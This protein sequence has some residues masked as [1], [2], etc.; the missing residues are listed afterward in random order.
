M[1]THKH[2]GSVRS[3]CRRLGV[4]FFVAAGLATVIAPVSAR[5]VPRNLGG[6]LGR[7]ATSPGA[8]SASATR[9][10]APG[11]LATVGDTGAV[12]TVSPVTV[13][14]AAG[15]VL[16]LVTLNGKEPVD[17]VAQRLRALPGVDVR[18]TDAHY[19]AGVV[20][21]LVP[22]AQLAGIATM[23]S[24]LAVVPSSPVVHDVGAATSQGV[25]QHRV[26]K[27]SAGVD[28]SGITVGVLSDSYDTS[29]SPIKAADDIA[30]GDLP[31]PGNPLGNTQPVVVLQ[32]FPDGTD[33]GRAML[34]IVHDLAPKARLGFATA[35]TGEV[36]F[37]NNIR[38]LAGLPGAPGAIPGFKADVIADDVVYLAEPFFQDGIIAQAVD[39]VADAGV[40]YFSSA[41]NRPASQA[42]DSKL[43][44]VPADPSSW[45]GTNLDFSD[46][47][48]AL[49]AGGFHNFAEDGSLDIA[50]TIAIGSS[51]TIVFQWNEPF[52]PVPPIPVQTLASGASTVPAD[53]GYDV[54][55]FTGT[56]G[57]I[58]AITVDGDPSHGNAN[59]D[60]TITLYGPDFGFLGFQ[61]STTNPETLILQLPSDGTYYV[62]VSGYNGALGDYVYTVQEVQI[63]ERVLS[64]FNLLF[65]LTDGTYIGALAEQNLFTNRPLELGGLGG[66]ITVQMVVARANVPDKHPKPADR[67]RYV[68]FTSGTPQEHFSYLGPVTYGHNCA[69]GAMGVAAYA[70]YP[71]FIPESFTSP[72]PATI[73]F[74]RN[75]RRYPIPQIRQKPDLAAM[76]GANTTFFG[77]G[78]A[79]QDPDTLPNF[80][81]TSAAAP[82][83]A[84]IAALVLDAA[85]GPGSVNPDRMRS[86]LQNSAF[87]HDLDPFFSWGAATARANLILVSATAD[88]NSISQFDPNVFT[89]RNYGLSPLANI[90]FNG[91]G[92]NTTETP[93]GIVF[94]TRVGPGQPFIIGSTSGLAPADVAASFSLPADPP[95]VADQWKQ[96]DLTFAAGAFKSG[97]MIGFGVDRDEADAFGP[98]AAVSGNS[99]DLL[100][101]GVL[102]PQGTI[103]PGGA[104]FFGTLQNGAKFSGKFYNLIGAGYSPVDGY[105]FINAEAAVKSVLKKKH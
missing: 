45:A 51:G 99:A 103:A 32:D 6:G 91:T 62:V 80:F 85:G 77:G 36:G 14:D 3:V 24:V 2:I 17:L 81:G 28:G 74:D 68:W 7:L 63:V 8:A 19:R 4:L 79:S 89:V 75:D 13:Q 102:I 76:D 66:P 73:Y 23:S 49:Y 27:L 59:P 37:A 44:I 104:T 31:G 95:G 38:A 41:G 105:G 5:P 10:L 46:V 57:K 48:P 65:F 101:A 50:Q 22:P 1:K 15:R 93:P 16:V 55:T 64:D 9:S 52:D 86:V 43:R 78:D 60:L 53:P 69:E 88:P 12:G 42:Y 39:D 34:Q 61:D 58:V 18:A 96:L 26:D 33:E 56:A 30:S 87:N 72:G 83:A 98:S 11:Q 35:D 54:F 92:G 97:G 25:V 29:D 82:H 67:I 94:D 90:S 70:F 21:A 40:S 100:G 47:D 71:P 84:A 20:E